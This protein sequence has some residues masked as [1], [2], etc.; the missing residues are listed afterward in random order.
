MRAGDWAWGPPA[1]G[2]FPGEDVDACAARELLQETGLDMP[3][4]RAD[5]PS[6]DWPTYLAEAPVDA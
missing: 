4:R 1:G 5:V 6:Q 2:R 3:V